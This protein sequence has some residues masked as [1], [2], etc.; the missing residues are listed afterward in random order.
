MGIMYHGYHGIIID[1][2]KPY[3]CGFLNTVRLSQ[4]PVYVVYIVLGLINW[5][6]TKIIVANQCYFNTVPVGLAFI[7]FTIE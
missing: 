6:L 4:Q 2:G 5:L 7:E 1:I 3:K